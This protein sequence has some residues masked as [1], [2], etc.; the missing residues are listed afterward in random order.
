MAFIPFAA[1]ETMAHTAQPIA[2][3]AGKGQEEKSQF[4]AGL[5]LPGIYT[6]DRTAELAEKF[7]KFSQISSCTVSHHL[8]IISQSPLN[9]VYGRRAMALEV[10]DPLE[11]DLSC[12]SPPAVPAR[13]P[14]S[15][16]PSVYSL[17][18]VGV[19][20]VDSTGIVVTTHYV[21]PASAAGSDI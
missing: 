20:M 19:G 15:S 8:L 5:P 4:L 1:A 6:H 21:R 2:A 13:E 11:V 16:V 10:V 3:L 18:L 14:A 9:S 17:V 7:S 12:L